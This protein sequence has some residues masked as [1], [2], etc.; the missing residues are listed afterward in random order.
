MPKYAIAIGISDFD[1]HNSIPGSSATAVKAARARDPSSDLI[2][3]PK[4]PKKEIVE[5]HM[6]RT[7]K[8]NTTALAYYNE[9]PQPE[10]RIAGTSGE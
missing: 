7:A 1:P 2:G 3:K 6:S 10:T 8:P 4:S 9:E 5:T